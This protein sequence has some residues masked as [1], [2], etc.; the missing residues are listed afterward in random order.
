[1]LW[2]RPHRSLHVC[3][4]VKL[5]LFKSA[6][7]SKFRVISKY[8]ALPAPFLPWKA[9]DQKWSRGLSLAWLHFCLPLGRR[10]WDDGGRVTVFTSKLR[11]MN[12][13][14]LICKSRGHMPPEASCAAAAASPASAHPAL[15]SKAQAHLPG[16]AGSQ[17]SCSFPLSSGCF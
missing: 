1:M 14:S 5:S 11:G 6:L 15:G 13:L 4:S 8:S 2:Q 3:L 7:H 12:F 16:L 9:R 10:E 17:P